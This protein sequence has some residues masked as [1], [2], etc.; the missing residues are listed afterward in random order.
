MGNNPSSDF[1]EMRNRPVLVSWED[2]VA[3]C[4]KLVE[5]DRAERHA[6]FK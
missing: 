2:A 4:K 3:F 5:N 1:K 6:N